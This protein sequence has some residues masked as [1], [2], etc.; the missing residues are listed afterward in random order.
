MTV[1]TLGKATSDC[2]KGV[3]A[4]GQVFETV[5]TIALKD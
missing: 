4:P 2:V 3:A 1:E 5:V